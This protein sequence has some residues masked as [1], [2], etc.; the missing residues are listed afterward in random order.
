MSEYRALTLGS[1]CGIIAR[2]EV[3]MDS[4]KEK[5]YI[6]FDKVTEMINMLYS[7]QLE[8]KNLLHSQKE[9]SFQPAFTSKNK[10]CFSQAGK[11]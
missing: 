9:E 1:Y 3:N 7:I 2:G 11:M 8:T 4:N 10:N 6:L 5:D